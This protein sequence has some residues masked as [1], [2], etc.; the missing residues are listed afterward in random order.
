MT[1]KDIHRGSTYD[2]DYRN[3]KLH[4]VKSDAGYGPTPDAIGRIH[5]T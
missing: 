3:P 1:T 4:S 2:V 5:K